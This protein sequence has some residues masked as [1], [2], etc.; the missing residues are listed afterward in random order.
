MDEIKVKIGSLVIVVDVV[1]DEFES[2]LN[3]STDDAVGSVTHNFNN[4]SPHY[5]KL[6]LAVIEFNKEKKRIDENG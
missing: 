3:M 2:L 5:Q 1:D 6:A 4:L